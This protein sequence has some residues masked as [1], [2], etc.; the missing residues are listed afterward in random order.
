MG[1]VMSVCAAV[2]SL[3][4]CFAHFSDFQ[5][6]TR[7]A[8]SCRSWNERPFLEFLDWITLFFFF[9]PLFRLSRLDFSIGSQWRWTWP[10]RM[11]SVLLPHTHWNR[12][13]CWG[14]G[15]MASIPNLFEIIRDCCLLYL[16]LLLLYYIR[17]NDVCGPDAFIIASLSPSGRGRCWKTGERGTG[18]LTFD[19]NNSC[20]FPNV[21]RQLKIRKQN[22]ATVYTHIVRFFI[23][24]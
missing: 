6:G 23:S 19:N 22:R 16:F 14:W 7:F 15:K 3:C 13:H 9:L 24:S 18:M 8:V 2:L 4:F 1:P 12:P 20:L 17:W 10:H 21:V 5:W 11:L